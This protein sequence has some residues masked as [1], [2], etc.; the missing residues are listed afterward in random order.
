M[1]QTR[2]KHGKKASHSAIRPFGH[3][4]D[5]F[6]SENRWLLPGHLCQQHLWR[7]LPSTWSNHPV[8]SDSNHEKQVLKRLCSQL[9]SDHAPLQ[10]C[11][12]FRLRESI[13]F[14]SVHLSSQN[15]LCR[16]SF[17]CLS[18]CLSPW[19]RQRAALWQL[20]LNE[21][22]TPEASE[23]NSAKCKK[24]ASHKPRFKLCCGAYML[25]I[26]RMLSSSFD[27]FHYWWILLTLKW[28][29]TEN[30]TKTLSPCP[31][32]IASNSSSNKSSKSSLNLMDFW[33][34]SGFRK[35]PKMHHD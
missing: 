11:Y 19:P 14:E 5:I 33:A 34:K 26:F 16:S 25:V 4:L 9:S 24:N 8:E 6:R 17:L 13:Y 35:I 7:P 27:P 23:P 18:F 31:M 10:S 15:F 32:Q 2:T 29:E 30:S 22:C 21:M 12:N 20:H 1:K 3:S 28:F